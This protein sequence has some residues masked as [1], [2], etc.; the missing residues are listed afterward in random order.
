MYNYIH[1][2]DLFL[3]D[4]DASGMCLDQNAAEDGITKFK[5]K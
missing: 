1:L 5:S 2:T 3:N 4:Q